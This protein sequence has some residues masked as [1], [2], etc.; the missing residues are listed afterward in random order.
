[1][2][3]G[4]GIQSQA[5]TGQMGTGGG[6][7]G[8]V[9]QGGAPVTGA[10][11][12]YGYSPFTMTQIYDNPS[13]M[14]GD[15]LENKLGITNQALADVL[16][17]FFDPALGSWFL[18]NSGDPNKATD[19]ETLNGVL[20]YMGQLTTPNGEM[21]D[22]VS[23]LNNLFGATSGDTPLGSYLQYDPK[24]GRAL[25]ASDQVG[26][27]N[28]LMSSQLMGLNPYAQEAYAGAIGRA[29]RDYL[30]AGQRLGS[31]GAPDPG[32]SYIDY[33]GGTPLRDWFAR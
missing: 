33:L 14:T 28:Q 9:A 12:D 13:I 25:S 23:L 26:N 32:S 16:A 18:A 7:T 4:G 30:E 5:P 29:G 1:M 22:Y 24:T 2:G 21:P 3:T 19:A 10:I 8:G 11:A 17:Q 27:A 31:T 6:A 15:M 20:E